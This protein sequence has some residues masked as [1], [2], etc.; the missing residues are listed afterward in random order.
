ML[1]GIASERAESNGRTFLPLSFHIHLTL[2]WLNPLMMGS[3][4]SS[5]ENSMRD[6]HLEILWVSFPSRLA[7]VRECCGLFGDSILGRSF[8]LWGSFMIFQNVQRLFRTLVVDALID[9]L[10]RRFPG[11][12]LG[13]SLGCLTWIQRRFRILWTVMVVNPFLV[14]AADSLTI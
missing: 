6:A 13:L 3:W 12:F 10:P 8:H 14:S 5:L 9:Q 7:V 1:W 2:F 11:F 4:D